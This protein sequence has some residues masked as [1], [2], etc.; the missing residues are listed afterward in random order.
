MNNWPLLYS[1]SNRNR[2]KIQKNGVCILP[3]GRP[4]KKAIRKEYRMMSDKERERFHAAIIHL[5]RNGEFD[6]MAIIHAQFSI[7][8]GAHSGPAFLPWHREFMKRMEIALRQIDPDLSLP[9]WDS[10]LDS[11]LPEPKDAVLWTEGLLG[12]TDQDGHVVTGDFADFVTFQNHPHITRKVGAQ[13]LPF[14]DSDI[15]YV[16]AQHRIEKVLA[17]TAPHEVE[18]FA[19]LFIA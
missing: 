6:K 3:N 5:K 17:H 4:L 13:G 12:T 15:E 16:L 18:S 9:Y 7:S 1:R 11:H 2:R 8:G 19:S 14:R 10:T